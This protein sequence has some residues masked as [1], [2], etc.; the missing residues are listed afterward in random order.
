M[1]EQHEEDCLC[2]FGPRIEGYRRR[3][4]YRFQGG[5]AKSFGMHPSDYNRIIHCERLRVSLMLKL[6]QFL[7]EIGIYTSIVDVE[8]DLALI[9]KR[10]FSEPDREILL[11]IMR[12]QFEKEGET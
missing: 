7:K 11:A 8:K 4:G 9:E 2:S 6:M 3:K 12:N 1:P 5:F 10:D